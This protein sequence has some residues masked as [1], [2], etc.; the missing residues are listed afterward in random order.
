M[1]IACRPVADDM[2][3]MFLRRLPFLSVMKALRRVNSSVCRA[4]MATLAR[5]DL[6]ALMRHDLILASQF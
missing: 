5:S 2:T 6:G 3:A 4:V 1:W